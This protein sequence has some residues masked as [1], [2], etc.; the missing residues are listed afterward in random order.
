MPLRSVVTPLS[1]MLC[2]GLA[3]AAPAQGRQNSTLRTAL[4]AYEN[5]EF[6]RAIALGNRALEQRLSAADQAR[7]YELLGFAYA[8]TDS[9]VKAVDA[10]KQ[11]ILLEPDRALDPARISP[12]VTSAFQ[13]ALSQVLVVRALA[14]DSAA[15]V[16]GQGGVPI[17]YTVTSP[18]RVLV[19]AIGGG[20]TIPIDSTVA[21]GQ[22]TLRWPATW[23]GGDPIPPGDY[24]LVVEATAGQNSFAASRAVRVSHGAVDT[25][26]HLTALPGYQFLSETEVPPKSW[27]PMGL[28][29]LYTGIATAGTLALESDQLGS[30]SRRELGAVSLVALAA[31]LVTTMRKP[32]P[33]AA[34]ANILYNRLLRD[35]LAQRN[36]EIARENAG[37]RQQVEVR[38]MPLPRAAAG[39]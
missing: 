35:Q 1:A 26:P 16:G 28:A 7:A 37:R 17:R 34:R 30:G 12:K 15:F 13:L 11:L 39:P 33:Q 22:V 27:R 3:V 18:A 29:F 6:S 9:P 36:E 23:H 19:R 25:L 4:S 20:R 38:V 8:A 10:F 32:P 2:A 31:G 14:V 24:T 5:L 21:T